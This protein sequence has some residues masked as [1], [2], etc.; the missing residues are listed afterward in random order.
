M[1]H[2]DEVGLQGRVEVIGPEGGAV[3]EAE[4]LHEDLCG[5]SIRTGNGEGAE[6]AF[7]LIGYLI[8]G[9]GV[10]LDGEGRL[11]AANAVLATE[12]RD[13]TTG[14]PVLQAPHQLTNLR[15]MGEH[16]VCDGDGW[17]V[18]HGGQWLVF[19]SKELLPFGERD[20]DLAMSLVANDLG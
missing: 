7:Y 11:D 16:A 20:E 6:E 2:L 18:G 13:S 3:F 19:S 5:Q 4:A 8:E 15:D 14:R 12:P 17:L 9:Q 1:G 10:V